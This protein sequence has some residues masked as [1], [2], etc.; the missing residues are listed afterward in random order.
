M[1]RSKQ[2]QLIS[3]WMCDVL[4]D[5][6][7][8]EDMISYRRKAMQQKFNIWQ[9]VSLANSVITCGSKGEGISKL[10]EN[11]WD[12][13]WLCNS[14]AC[15]EDVS[16]AE[17]IPGNY[18]IFLMDKNYTNPGYTSLKLHRHGEIII[19]SVLYSLKMCAFGNYQLSSEQ[20]SDIFVNISRM[21]RTADEE[22]LMTTNIEYNKSG[23][24]VTMSNCY[25]ER[26]EVT[27]FRCA[28]PCLLNQWLRRP[29]HDW[30]PVDVRL[31]I[32]SMDANLV[33]KG[34]KGS[35]NESFE[36]RICFNR[37]ELL[38]VQSLSRIQLNLYIIL[39]MILKK[40]FND[41]KKE[42]TSYVMKN[43]VFWLAEL[44]P[45]CVFLETNL[46]CWVIKSLRLLKR[47][48]NHYYLPYYMIPKRNLL[49]EN[50]E[51]HRRRPLIKIIST[52]LREGPQL[53]ASLPKLKIALTLTPEQLRYF[54]VKRD[55]LEKL[56]LSFTPMMIKLRAI[57]ALQHEIAL[58]EFL[59]TQGHQILDLNNVMEAIINSEWPVAIQ[60]ALAQYTLV[61]N[62]LLFLLS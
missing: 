37:G 41:D 61:E 23:P 36:W 32:V 16:S 15:I 6:G 14:I 57:S 40:V 28:C 22:L 31:Q 12:T 53:V 59:R 35:P 8:S 1:A 38:L 11:D 2:D 34:R 50:L 10:F 43:I 55:L 52:L 60:D 44:Y 27:S 9:F 47:A 7:Y 24:A 54:R 46:Y 62:K 29:R 56:F 48:I 19:A 17:F 20:F 3:K 45:Q 33:A 42:I 39:K 30:P 21:C 49:A 5:L 18:T 51:F 25:I 4:D 13:L 26:D 58:D